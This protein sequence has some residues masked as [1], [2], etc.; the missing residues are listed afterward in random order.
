MAKNNVSNGTS[1]GATQH[2][3]ASDRLTATPPDDIHKSNK[4][5][6]GFL[7]LSGSVYHL[8]INFDHDEY[9]FVGMSGL[10]TSC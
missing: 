7:G 2:S 3:T 4:A 6:R 8:T 10:V 5:I 9:F 1:G